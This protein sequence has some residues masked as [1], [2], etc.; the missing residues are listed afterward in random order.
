VPCALSSQY[1]A[2]YGYD[3][4]GQLTSMTTGSPSDVC[5]PTGTCS[6]GYDSIGNLTNHNGVAQSYPP[7]GQGHPHA[8]ASSGGEAFAYDPN[9][10]L[11]H[12]AGNLDIQWN[13][14]NMAQQV[15]RGG[16]TLTTKSFIGESVWKKVEAGATTYYLPEMRVE[17]GQS[18]KYF[19]SFAERD[20]DG[21]LK[22]Y[23]GDLLGSSSL[24][25]DAS[26][27]VVHRAA[28]M[29]YGADRAPTPVGTFT[30]K[31]QFNFKE[32]ETTT[33]LYDY[34]A[35]MYNPATGRWLSA[36]TD[37]KDG[38]N[39]YAYVSNNPLVHRDPT[40][41]QK[42]QLAT[43][44]VVPLIETL[45]K[46][47]TGGILLT[48]LDRNLKA[49]GLTVIVATIDQLGLDQK[50]V[51]ALRKVM[52]GGQMYTLPTDPNNAAAQKIDQ[53]PKTGRIT[54]LE[55]G[56]GSSS[57]IVINPA[58]P[59]TVR[60][61]GHELF[62]AL[63]A[64][65]GAMLAVQSSYDPLENA[66]YGRAL[67][68]YESAYLRRW[69]GLVSPPI[70]PTHEEEVTMGI[71]PYSGELLSEKTLSMELNLP[72]RI[73]HAQEEGKFPVQLPIPPG[74]EPTPPQ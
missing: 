6:Y 15:S 54:I 4:L 41:H 56:K 57:V 59:P 17:N 74:L 24:V 33:G 60:A 34:G 1:S 5:A 50:T 25:T 36:D 58:S 20:T 31:L 42:L 14:E 23:H 19:S 49:K 73:S 45:E 9:G 32:K 46:T 7:V 71:G 43:P 28:Y 53:D 26:G 16:A 39:R 18:R 21:S 35:R 52:I 63:H 64:A 61:L 12:G 72:P 47:K 48:E 62:H 13:A 44:E 30:P 29:P 69:L 22:Y 65:Q 10:N 70:P 37:S 66:S 27:A 3:S 68:A 40:G 67:K 11:T 8:P 55:H 2:S 51:E 38:L